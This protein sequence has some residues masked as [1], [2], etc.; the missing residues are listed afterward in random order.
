ME[1]EVEFD[2]KS[3][4][5]IQIYR[6]YS[7]QDAISKFRKKVENY[8][9]SIIFFCDGKI[10]DNYNITIWEKRKSLHLDKLKILVVDKVKEKIS[11]NFKYNNKNT[12]IESKSNEIMKDIFK[13]F[14]LKISS[15]SKSFYF[16]YRGRILIDK[17]E[18]N[19]YL[20][21][22][23]KERKEMDIIVTKKNSIVPNE[24][25]IIKSKQIICPICG[26][27][28]KIK[29]NNYSISINEC[30]YDHNI[31]DINLD[32]FENSQLINISQI[33]CN[34]CKES[35]KKK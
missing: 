10:I 7:I 23:K 28:A 29:F 19:Q 30:K 8:D 35:N 2:Y 21:Y 4:V 20:N 17:F 25:S 31:E 11:V 34:K 15:N 26:E 16:W 5:K 24:E 33:I 27:L 1:E 13:K 3:I 9:D 12:I 6:D 18:I 32:E 14:A 22:D